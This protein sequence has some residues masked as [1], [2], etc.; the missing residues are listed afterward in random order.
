MTLPINTRI[1]LS[2]ASIAAAGALVAGSTFAFFS[3]S[4]TST[5]NVFAAG[6]LELQLDDL[7][8]TSTSASISSSFGGSNLAPGGPGVTG[9]VSLHNSGTINMAEVRLSATEIVTSTPDLA[10]KLNITSAKIGTESTCTTG[11][12]DISGSFTTLAALN[13]AGLDLP[14]SAVAAGATKYLCMTFVLDSGTDDTYQGKSIT[15]TFTFDGH[16]D[17]TQ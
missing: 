17:L 15:E 11:P 3:D 2:A 9:F 12:S 7:N 5:G 4:N 1:L 8:E 10:G 16:Q 14:S 6:T 13:S